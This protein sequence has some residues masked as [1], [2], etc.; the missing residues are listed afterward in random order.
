MS[1]QS[2]H[3]ALMERIATFSAYSA[4]GSVAVAGWSMQEWFGVIG[5]ILAVLTFV[6]NIYYK[7]S[8]K[9]HQQRMQ[10]IAQGKDDAK[11]ST[12]DL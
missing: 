8:T 4:S 3:D 5:I 6:V 2:I 10:E 1:R 12:D 9:K 7:E 11:K